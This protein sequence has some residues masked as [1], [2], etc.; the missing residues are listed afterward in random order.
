[1]QDDRDLRTVSPRGH[2]VDEYWNGLTQSIEESEKTTGKMA[3]S[4]E[5]SGMKI[6]L[7]MLIDFL[8]QKTYHE[9]TVL[10]EL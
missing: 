2:W 8:L 5:S 4:S 6:N 9:L 3:P 10:S 7:S 1:M